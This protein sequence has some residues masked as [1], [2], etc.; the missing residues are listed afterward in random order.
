MKLRELTSKEHLEPDRVYIIGDSEHKVL[1]FLEDLRVAIPHVALFT[2]SK[3]TYRFYLATTEINQL[4]R[5]VVSLPCGGTCVV[6]EI[7]KTFN[8]S[9]VSN[10]AKQMGLDL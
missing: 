1:S 9:S 8:L 10:K 6:R 2:D 5:E 3:Q 7:P 4:S